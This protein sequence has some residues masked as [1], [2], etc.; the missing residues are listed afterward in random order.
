MVCGMVSRMKTRL[1]A[2][3]APVLTALGLVSTGPR[4]CA[5]H[6]VFSQDGERVYYMQW[7]DAMKGK[8]LE[9]D[10]MKE[11]VSELDLR[12]FVKADQIRGICRSKDGNLLVATE[13]GAWACDTAKKTA[14]KLCAAPEGKRFADIV[15]DPKLRGILL[16]TW[17]DNDKESAVFLEDG[18]KEP[19]SVG[20]RRVWRFQGMDFLAD[21]TSFFG[22][23]G[24]LWMGNFTLEK[25]RSGGRV[26]TEGIRCAPLA[27]RETALGTSDETG[28]QEVA[29]AG[30]KVY[31]HLKRLG[32]T[33]H[34]EIVR[35]AMPEFPRAEWYDNEKR[36]KLYA[37]ECAS[38][39]FL[40][41]S[42]IAAR[43]CASPD[44]RRV[45]FYGGITDP[46]ARKCF[47]IEDGG[48]PKELHVEFPR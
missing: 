36:L 31:V 25:D 7:S 29:I 41:K 44:G 19:I 16:P 34:G 10:V 21:G 22:T 9:I 32:G 47:L 43:L 35:V 15:Y 18:A 38:A 33:G 46:H 8:L 11:T 5:G 40:G 3:L 27:T 2:F 20:M 12:E 24:D 13:S 42:A 1:P 30:K 17:E 4:A 23:D 37:A 39:E 26:I 45:F 48:A 6:G 28:V 14:R